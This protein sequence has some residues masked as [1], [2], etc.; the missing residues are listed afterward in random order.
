MLMTAGC[1][2]SREG[3][4]G[5]SP[6]ETSA[7]RIEV[8]AGWTGDEAAAFR[9]VLAG[10]TQKT[11]IN[12]D[13]ES[14]EQDLPTIL[15]GRV[16]GGDPPDVAVLA[17]PGLLKELATLGELV[18]VE[19]AV[20]SSVDQNYARVW[21]DL[22]SVDGTLY[23]VFFKGANKSTVW[24]DVKVFEA[25]GL[26]PPK[27]WDDWVALSQELLEAGITP[28]AV[29]GADGWVLSDWF[30]NVYLRTAGAEK[31]DQLA[32]HEI[33]WTDQS[34]KDALAI[35]GELIGVEDYVARGLD[36][37]TEVDWRESVKLVFSDA[38]EAAVVYEG[39]F[40]AGEIISETDA[41]PGTDFAFFEW[42]S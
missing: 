28:I 29:G 22:G 18:P 31:Y 4:T 17:Q 6:P 15:S 14:V 24:Y 2:D 37:A 34:V 12:V 20:G 26:A 35:M 7:G 42:P 3:A 11:G 36:G 8:M 33:P 1:V 10:F 5:T 40:V 38:P 23:G 39:D 25:H 21:R 19:S 16:D 13:F 30:E 9:Q 32:E 27:T 41:R